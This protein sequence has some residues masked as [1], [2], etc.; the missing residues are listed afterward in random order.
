MIIVTCIF[1]DTWELRYGIHVSFHPN[2]LITDEY[3]MHSTVLS[4]SIRLAPGNDLFAMSINATSQ[5]KPSDR[6]FTSGNNTQI[7]LI[8]YDVKGIISLEKSENNIFFESASTII[9]QNKIL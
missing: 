4:D 1:F 9:E 7:K 5:G 2:T 8:E 3:G 6:S